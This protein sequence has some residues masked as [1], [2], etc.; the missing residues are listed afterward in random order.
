MRSTSSSSAPTQ[1]TTSPNDTHEDDLCEMKATV[2][3]Q[4]WIFTAPRDDWR[5]HLHRDVLNAAEFQIDLMDDRDVEK[6][7]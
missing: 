3:G 1:H 4:E 6:L 7:D 5:D 2:L